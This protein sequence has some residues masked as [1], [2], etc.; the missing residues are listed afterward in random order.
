MVT[1]ADNGID[2]NRPYLNIAPILIHSCF[3]Y[4]V[5]KPT[6]LYPH[7][8]V[9]SCLPAASLIEQTFLDFYLLLCVFVFAFVCWFL[10]CSF[11]SY[12]YCSKTVPETNKPS[13]YAVLSISNHNI[14]QFKFTWNT[15]LF[16]R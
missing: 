3:T 2:I 11:V 6:I 1:H 10:C 15:V 16:K 13:K 9:G 14:Q 4:A 8:T 12:Y 7:C 5:P